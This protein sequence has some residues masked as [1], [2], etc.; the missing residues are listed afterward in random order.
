MVDVSF[1]FSIS[2]NLVNFCRVFINA[3]T[4]R[5]GIQVGGVGSKYG[6]VGTWSTA[7]HENLGPVGPFWFVFNLSM[8]GCR[9]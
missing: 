5:N 7:S 3:L 8:G 2:Y 9:H 6:V 1:F 4:C